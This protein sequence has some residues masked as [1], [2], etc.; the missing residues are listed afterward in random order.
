[1]SKKIVSILI[2]LIFTA[3]AVIAQP[4]SVSAAILEDCKAPVYPAEDKPLEL[5]PLNDFGYR[6]AFEKA[7][8]NYHTYVECIFNGAVGSLLGSAGGDTKG[9]F[10]ANAPNLPELIK[11]GSSCLAETNLTGL[12]KDGSPANILKPLLEAYNAY[13]AYLRRLF[14]LE[15]LNPTISASG[16]KLT[17]I[18][19]RNQAFSLILENEL[20]NAIVALNTSFISLKEL[21]QAFVIHVHFQCL[22]KNLEFYRRALENLRRVISAL[23]PIIKD[24]S[25][26]K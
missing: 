22:L 14:E 19:S 1:M 26:S 8:M 2:L 3:V 18:Y 13:A 17:E 24:A 21:R 6:V 10:S 7:R 12:L 16:G 11:P 5:K 9:I 15:S 23:P 25:I 4:L 20:Q